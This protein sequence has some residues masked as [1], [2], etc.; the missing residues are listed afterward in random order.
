M[1]HYELS[2]VTPFHNVDRSMFENCV[3]GMRKQT[4]GYE[5][6]EWVVV[7]HNCGPEYLAFAHEMLDGDENV[8]L[9]ELNNEIRSP[10]SPRNWG[11]KHATGTFLGFLDGDDSFTEECAATALDAIRR[12][13][14]DICVFRREFEL[15]RQGMLVVTELV[16][17]DQ[18]QRE[19][20]QEQGSFD[21][22][23]LFASNWGL[24]TSKLYRR[25][26]L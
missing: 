13:D 23:K 18:T 20:L 17:W 11:M 4:Y 22:E 2:I 9:L 21:N 3:A 26:F 14:A 12:N 19:I 1:K 10:S 16:L 8:R 7:L 24:V 6:I 5:N 15:E 25:A